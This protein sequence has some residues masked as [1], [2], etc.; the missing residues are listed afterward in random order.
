[1]VQT[2]ISAEREILNGI[3]SL[4]WGFRDLA[5]E[6]AVAGEP[7]DRS[8]LRVLGL[9]ERCEQPP[10]LSELASLINL[11]LS[12]LSRHCAT[13]TKDGLL[14][15]IE[16]TEDR[17]ACRFTIS[18]QGRELLSKVIQSRLKAL[19]TIMHDWSES[20]K[21]EVARTLEKLTDALNGY[22]GNGK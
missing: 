14:T 21:V 5:T 13:L 3:I 11:D 20:E 16:D 19:A 6:L 4:V 18:S 8:A 9:V 17:R 7:S 15:R 12:T 10:R 22:Q 1:M 2:T